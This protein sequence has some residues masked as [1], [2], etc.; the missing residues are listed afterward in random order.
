MVQSRV[1]KWSTFCFQFL[2]ADVDH[3]LTLDFCFQFLFLMFF[4]TS[5]SL[6]KEEYLKTKEK[7]HKKKENT[8]HFLT[9][10]PPQCG[11]LI[12]PTT[13]KHQQ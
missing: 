10:K 12:D 9:L 8:D 7:Q 1:N 5:F 13:Y 11:R 3:L 2:E 6:Q 4:K